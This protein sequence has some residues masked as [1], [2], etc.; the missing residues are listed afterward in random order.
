EEL[1][2][3][4]KLTVEDSD[5]EA[6]AEQEAGKIGIDKERL[7]NIYRTSDQIR[8]RLL[9]DRLIDHLMKSSTI[10]DVEAQDQPE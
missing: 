10:K 3:A 5:L 9:G 1:I 6:L 7:V 4:E 8:D 2:K